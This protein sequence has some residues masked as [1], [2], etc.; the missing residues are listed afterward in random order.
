[1]EVSILQHAKDTS[2]KAVG[3]SEIVD[4]IRGDQWPPGYQPVLLVQG[5]FDGGSSTRRPSSS[6]TTTTR[7]C[8]AYSPCATA[9]STGSLA[10]RRPP[11]TRATAASRWPIWNE[12]VYRYYS[13]PAGRDTG[14][15][16]DVATAM[17]QMAGNMTQKLRKEAVDQA[18]IDLGF[19][20]MVCDGLPGYLAIRRKPEEINA[21][22]RQ[23]A[24]RTAQPHE[25]VK[26]DPEIPDHF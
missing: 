13:H 18:F 26:Q 15:F 16:V 1:M 10:T 3:I 11:S 7:A 8:W 22:G 14:E 23:L 21:L 24:Q 19:E 12:L 20:A 2:P 17:Q 9:S 6:A 4:L 25:A 5:T